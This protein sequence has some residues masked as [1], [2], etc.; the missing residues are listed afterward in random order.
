MKKA[1]WMAAAALLALAACNKNSK[2]DTLPVDF[3]QYK[4]N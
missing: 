1:F 3:S 4:R 2:P